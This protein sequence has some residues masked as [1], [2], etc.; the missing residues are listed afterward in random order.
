M[1]QPQTYTNKDL[2]KPLS[3]RPGSLSKVYTNKDLKV[4]DDFEPDDSDFV[5]DSSE[6]TDDFQPDESPSNNISV[7]AENA[8]DSWS[9]GFINSITSGEALGAGLSGLKGFAK[10]ATFDIPE[11]II[12]GIKGAYNLVTDPINT[13]KSI[14]P[15]IKAMMEL[16]EQAGARPEEFG[17][18]MGQMTGQ[19]LTTAGLVKAAPSITRGAGAVL[20]P[21][22]RMMRRHQ[23]LTGMPIISPFAGRNLQKLERYAGRGLENVGQRM[24]QVGKPNRVKAIND[25]VSEPGDSPL[26]EG[27]PISPDMELSYR[28]PLVKEP[29][30]APTKPKVRLNPDGTYTNLDTGEIFD[31]TG[32]PMALPSEAPITKDSSFFNQNRSLDKRPL[33][34][35][36]SEIEGLPEQAPNNPLAALEAPSLE[37]EIQN[38]LNQSKNKSQHPLDIK[39]E[40]GSVTVK[41]S[42]LK[43]LGSNKQTMPRDIFDKLISEGWTVKGATL[44]QAWPPGN[45]KHPNVRVVQI[46]SSDKRPM[47]FEPPK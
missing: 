31:S 35:R 15:G 24:R 14:P 19:P 43:Q 34:E 2:G 25:K 5:A 33:R 44:D 38:I 4:D 9:E 13:I 18:M 46:S 16:T 11:S 42:I 41:N 23:P 36:I 32:K 10:G 26:V 8:P 22:G 37:E 47:I 12:G 29:V 17:R 1:A 39:G 27:Q 20:E 40:K 7:V 6:E 21:T 30:A 28:K 3:K 45:P